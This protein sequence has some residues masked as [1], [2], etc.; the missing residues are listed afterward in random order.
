MELWAKIIPRLITS[1]LSIIDSA[2]LR[3]KIFEIQNEHELMW[4]ALDDIARMYRDHPAGN[5]AKAT[6]E[7][8]KRKYGR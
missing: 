1:L 7:Q 4:T 5:Y 3:N 2:N 6:L 8:I